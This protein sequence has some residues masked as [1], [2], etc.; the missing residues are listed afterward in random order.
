MGP[1]A[2]GHQHPTRPRSPG[3][4]KRRR[5]PQTVPAAGARSSGRP[6]RSSAVRVWR[7]C[8]T[9]WLHRQRGSIGSVAVP[10][11]RRGRERRSWRPSAGCSSRAP[12]TRRRSRRS[13]ASLASRERRSTSASGPGVGLL[14][15]SCA[16]SDKPSMI[17]I[18][19]AQKHPLSIHRA[20]AQRLAVRTDARSHFR[21]PRGLLAEPAQ[22]S[23]SPRAGHRHGAPRRPPSRRRP[24]LFA[25]SLDPSAASRS[26]RATA[27]AP[28]AHHQR[29]RPGAHHGRPSPP[30]PIAQRDVGDPQRSRKLALAAGHPAERDSDR[31]RRQELLGIRRPVLGT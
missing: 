25:S 26:H 9:R 21:R 4:H 10:R 23:V 7:G 27:E 20:Y 28:H 11:A 3:G 16:L 18:Q 6:E 1:V 13:P 14:E 12:S 5:Q 8:F 29:A 30:A 17:A 2:A 24:P 22:T 31:L 19:A 15:A